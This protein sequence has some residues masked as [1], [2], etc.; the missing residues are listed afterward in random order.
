M[1]RY[2][3]F[4]TGLERKFAFAV[5]NSSDIRFFGGVNATT[6]E[7][8]E[9]EQ[10]KHVWSYD[11]DAKDILITLQSYVNNTGLAIP[12]FSAFDSNLEGTGKLRNWLNNRGSVYCERIGAKGFFTFELGCVIYHQ[13]KYQPEL[14]ARYEP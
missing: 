9:Y 11:R 6:A 7:N 14:E 8:R 2:A 12:D 10:Y 1:G 4:N 13:L 3:F 5:Q